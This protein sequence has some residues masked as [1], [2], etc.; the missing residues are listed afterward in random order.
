MTETRNYF[1]AITQDGFSEGGNRVA[2]CDVIE[3]RLKSNSWPL[4]ENTKNRRVI[5]EG[6]TLFFYVGGQ[7]THGGDIIA[8]AQV[9][10][11]IDA[12][13]R[14]LR[15]EYATSPVSALISLK[16][17]KF[18]APISLKPVLIECGIIKKENKKWGVFLM[19]GLCRVSKAVA[20][21]LS[22]PAR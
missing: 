17:I 15:D 10:D 14:T 21:K 18:F 20:N 7:G 2:A 19:G 12:G 3:A 13:R 4:Y 1:V 8:T 22:E 5:S 11:R 6:D 16:E 9:V